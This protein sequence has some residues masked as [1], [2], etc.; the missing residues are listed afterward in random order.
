[1]FE[2]RRREAG[3]R[4]SKS[5]AGINGLVDIPTLSVEG[6]ISLRK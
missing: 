6:N 3:E 1:M 5:V 2:V 4:V